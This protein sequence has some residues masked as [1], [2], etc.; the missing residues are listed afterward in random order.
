MDLGS[1]I[2]QILAESY[3]RPEV[4]IRKYVGNCQW[5]RRVKAGV[6]DEPGL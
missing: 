2:T 4:K 6:F 1:I 5:F 3:R